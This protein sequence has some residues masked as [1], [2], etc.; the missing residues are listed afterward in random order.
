MSSLGSE[1]NSQD[2]L[3]GLNTDFGSNNTPSDKIKNSRTSAKSSGDGNVT[4]TL[5]RCTSSELELTGVW[6]R[7][8]KAKLEGTVT[9]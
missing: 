6:N 9:Q 2:T 4:K 5:K 7:S 8:I 3:S 1:R